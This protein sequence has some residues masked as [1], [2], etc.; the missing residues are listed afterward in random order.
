MNDGHEISSRILDKGSVCACCSF[1][2]SKDGVLDGL[3]ALGI[4]SEPHILQYPHFLCQPP[5][6]L[7]TVQNLFDDPDARGAGDAGQ[8]A[9]LENW[10]SDGLVQVPADLV[11][12]C[13]GLDALDGRVISQSRDRREGDEE[14]ETNKGLR[15]LMQG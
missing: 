10:L 1:Q 12:V 15:L 13:A 5:L 2:F 3:F 8:A 11:D 14:E 9:R 4:F 6:A 7:G